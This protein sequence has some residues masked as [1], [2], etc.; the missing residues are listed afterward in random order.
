[1]TSARCRLG[2]A[3]LLALT[4]L[5][6]SIAAVADGDCP[7]YAGSWPPLAGPV[8]ALASA[9]GL[10]YFGIGTAFAVGDLSNPGAAVV[11]GSAALPERARAVTVTGDRA[12]VATERGGLQIFD[13]SVPE[14]PLELGRLQPTASV[15]GVAVDEGYAYLVSSSA[16]MAV[17]DVRT[18]E[19]PVVVA[20]VDYPVTG[21]DIEVRSG[22]AFVAGGAVLHVVDVTTPESPVRVAGVRAPA[23]SLAL[24]GDFA[25]VAGGSGTL[26]KIDVSSPFN[27]VTV[28]EYPVTGRVNAV[29]VGEGRVYLA[30]GHELRVLPEAAPGGWSLAVPGVLGM[31][32]ESVDVTVADGGAVVAAAGAGLVAVE[33]VDPSSPVEVG[34]LATTGTVLDVAV[35]DTRAYVADCSYMG[36]SDYRPILPCRLRVLDLDA[37]GAASQLGAVDL[38][39]MPRNVETVG[40]LV[41]VVG[42][43]GLRLI[44]ASD[45]SSPA[46]VGVVTWPGES[47]GG[48]ALADGFAYVL[49]EGPFTGVAVVD[50]RNPSLPVPAGSF[51]GHFSDIAVEGDRAFLTAP[52]EGNLVVLDV[53]EPPAPS[54][55][56][57]AEVP[58]VPGETS[59]PGR[60]AVAGGLAFITESSSTGIMLRAPRLWVFDV[61]D[62]STPE[63]VGTFETGGSV[64]EDLI[65]VGARSGLAYLASVRYDTSAKTVLY[66][67]SWVRIIDVSDPGL[68]T[69]CG[70]L[71]SVG[72][73]QQLTEVAGGFYLAD[74]W[75]GMHAF[76]T[77]IC[78]GTV[79]PPPRVRTPDRRVVP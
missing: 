39:E 54:E 53:S 40:D 29:A 60:I 69:L 22:F 66:G 13:V 52:G 56:A 38:E 23:W 28:D 78:E 37:G 51:P 63:L 45:P 17:V 24:S 58:S 72:N 20:T 33:A 48:V 74:G 4:F 3:A 70:A 46:V 32:G 16:R 50:V 64:F 21:R 44:T 49:L 59:V 67:S 18:P 62:P 25:Y 42:E 30:V 36:D 77:S 6:A 41:A 73:A 7:E 1:M 10:V 35:A 11:L 43:A 47:A 14:S 61:D 8:T 57:R 55:I 75:A 65:D 19:H 15:D 31:R 68:P 34:G 2:L 12:Y 76:D 9:G 71:E 26:S 79:P 27:P 5:M